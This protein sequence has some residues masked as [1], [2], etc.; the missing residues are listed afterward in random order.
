MS[1]RGFAALTAEQRRAISSK[2]GKSAHAI[3]SA[4]VFTSEEGRLAG[5]KGGATT[6]KDRA[7]MVKIGRMGGRVTSN[8][9]DHMAEIGKVGGAKRRT[10]P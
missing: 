4:H 9:A 7:H 3:G 8:D 6:S 5:R 1:K 2:G 10:A